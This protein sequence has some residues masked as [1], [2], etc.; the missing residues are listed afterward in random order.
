MTT[1]SGLSLSVH[2]TNQK[3]INEVIGQLI[4]GR[5]NAVGTFTLA[6]SPATTT[7]VTSVTCGPNSII[8]WAP[9]TAHAASTMTNVYLSTVK[10]NSFTVTHTAT[11]NSD[12]TFYYLA[13]G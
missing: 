4:Q 9:S 8:L 1:G 6:V 2:E 13:I 11:I 12:C 5:S 7:T 10:I 3:R